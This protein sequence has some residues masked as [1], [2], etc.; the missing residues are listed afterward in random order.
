MT[1]S[2]L[3]QM[4]SML[5]RDVNPDANTKYLITQNRP[6]TSKLNISVTLNTPVFSKSDYL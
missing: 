1:L 5:W 2:V 3:Q 4:T 6:L